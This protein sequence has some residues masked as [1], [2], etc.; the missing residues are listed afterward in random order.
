M[1]EIQIVLRTTRKRKH[2]VHKMVQDPVIPLKWNTE[3]QYIMVENPKSALLST[4]HSYDF[5]IFT[6]LTFQFLFLLWKGYEIFHERNEKRLVLSTFYENH[7]ISQEI[8]EDKYDEEPR[9]NPGQGQHKTLSS[10]QRSFEEESDKTQG[11]GEQ[12]ELT[13]QYQVIL[14]L[15]CSSGIYI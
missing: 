2:S 11:V 4:F 8:I 12:L 3:I 1:R 7:F 15:R 14:Y 13:A 9:L 10:K 6:L 5:P